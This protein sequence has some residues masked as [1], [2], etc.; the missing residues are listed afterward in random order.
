MLENYISVDALKVIMHKLDALDILTLF[1]DVPLKTQQD[2][3][4]FGA[5][6]VDFKA[7]CTSGKIKW[8]SG[9]SQPQ[10]ETLYFLQRS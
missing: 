9:S 5:F 7:H 6:F 3:E 4:E 1:A 10:Y 2:R 8:G